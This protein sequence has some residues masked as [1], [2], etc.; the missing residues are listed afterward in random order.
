[1]I[2]EYGQNPRVGDKYA[3]Q[4]VAVS[5]VEKELV[6]VL[7]TAAGIKPGTAARQ[8]L[9]RGLEGYLQDM[10]L[11][12]DEFDVTVVERLQ[13]LVATDPK[14]KRAAEIVRA[15]RPASPTVPEAE[16]KVEEAPAASNQLQ[17]HSLT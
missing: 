17:Q 16:I 2:L 4:G 7:A 14:L 10:K 9:F 15:D 5:D 1:M 12:G 8:L 13:K 11:Q 6:R 3:N